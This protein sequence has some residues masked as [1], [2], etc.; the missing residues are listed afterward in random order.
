MSKVPNPYGKKGNPDHQ[1]LIAHLFS[2]LRSDNK[3]PRMEAPIDLPDGRKRFADVV[4]R[5]ENG[6]ITEIHQVGRTNKDGS[7]VKRERDAIDDIEKSSVVKV[8]FHALKIVF[9]IAVSMVL[10]NLIF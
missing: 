3:N 9:I 6:D 1:N 8:I 2:L 5:D 7:K 10:L 4:A